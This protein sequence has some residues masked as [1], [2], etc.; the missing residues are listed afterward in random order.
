[1]RDTRLGRTNDGSRD[2]SRLPSDVQLLPILLFACILLPFQLKPL[3]PQSLD[4]QSH[5]LNMKL[6]HADGVQTVHFHDEF[7][8]GIAGEAKDLSLLGSG[9]SL[10]FFFG[11][12]VTKITTNATLRLNYAAPN[13][14]SNEA[15]LELTL[16][17]AEVGSIVLSPGPVQQTEFALPTD[18]LTNDNALSFQLQGTCAS[19]AS[20]RTPWVTLDP[21]STVNLGGT[22]LPLANDLS[23]LPLPF[24]DPSGLR[25]WSLPLVFGDSPDEIT[26]NSEALVASWFGVLSDVRSVHFPVSVGEF[27]M[28]TQLYSRCATRVFSPACRCHP[29]RGH[30][31]R[32]AI[33]LATPTASY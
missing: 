9:A 30:F 3:E 7:E 12:P 25:S 32:C 16:N 22:G 10:N 17:G 23:L 19:C 20:K 26:L 31:S 6:K 21:R 1:V 2:V 14:R 4:T 13:L 18:L 28:E 15:R 27:P 29:S 5:G 8:L 11:E 24:F 33:I